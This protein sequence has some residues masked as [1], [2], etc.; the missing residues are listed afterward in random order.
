[1]RTPLF[2]VLRMM[3]L[4]GGSEHKRRLPVSPFSL[5]AREWIA[6]SGRYLAGPYIA[7]GGLRIPDRTRNWETICAQAYQ[8]AGQRR[9]CRALCEMQG[10]NSRLRRAPRLRCIALRWASNPRSGA[11]AV[12]RR[13]GLSILTGSDPSKACSAASMRIRCVVRYYVLGGSCAATQTG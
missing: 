13:V 6:Q 10:E 11:T 2:A 4:Q 12:M 7:D 8:L 9:Q 5:M 3:A 1:M